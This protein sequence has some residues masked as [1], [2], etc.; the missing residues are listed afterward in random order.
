[1][2]HDDDGIG[3]SDCQRWLPLSEAG[4]GRKSTVLELWKNLALP[5]S[6]L[7]NLKKITVVF[8]HST[9]SPLLGKPQDPDQR[10]WCSP[11]RLP[12]VAGQAA[13]PSLPTH[14]PTKWEWGKQNPHAQSGAQQS[15]VSRAIRSFG[16]AAGSICE[17]KHS[18]YCWTSG[19]Q[20]RWQ[21]LANIMY[22]TSSISLIHR[23]MPSKDHRLAMS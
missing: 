7:Q 13:V 10:A 19:Q 4:T 6:V 9:C 11:T 22:H 15:P 23:L 1:M 17:A 8:K 5:I 2:P 20:P 12:L 16:Q 14:H 18:P 21:S 3:W